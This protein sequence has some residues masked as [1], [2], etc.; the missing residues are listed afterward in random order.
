MSTIPNVVSDNAK[1]GRNLNST[2]VPMFVCDKR[3]IPHNG[4]AGNGFPLA[5][6]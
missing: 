4:I 6:K 1:S 3:F 5:P 2:E